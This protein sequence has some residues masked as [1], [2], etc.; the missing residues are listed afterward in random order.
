MRPLPLALAAVLAVPCLAQEFDRDKAGEALAAFWKV[1]KDEVLGAGTL[2]AKDAPAADPAGRQVCPVHRVPM[3]EF[4]LEKETTQDSPD[5]PAIVE[6]QH[7]AFFCP[8]AP[9]VYVRTE[10]RGAEPTWRGPFTDPSFPLERAKPVEIPVGPKPDPGKGGPTRDQVMKLLMRHITDSGEQGYFAN[11]YQDIKDLGPGAADHLIAIFETSKDKQLKHLAV[12]ALGEVA[13]AAAVP[14]LQRLASETKNQEYSLSLAVALHRLGEP[15]EVERMLER[16]KARLEEETGPATKA[17]ILGGMGLIYSLI[18]KEDEA[19]GAYQEATKLDP[20]NS[21]AFYN[22]ACSYSK[23]GRV[24]DALAALEGALKA[25]YD[26][27]EWMMVDGDLEAIRGDDRF[28][29]LY[30]TYRK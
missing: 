23:L 11:R 7:V 14:K 19:L 27:W 6:R 12:E 5:A 29:G 9:E 17:S 28:K 15:A 16:S 25:G 2:A 18:G 8:R 24:D 13:D 3:L 1:R 4:G 20:D 22:L 30:K 10:A 21:I 26:D